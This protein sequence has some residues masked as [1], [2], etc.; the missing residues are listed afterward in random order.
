MNN[1]PMSNPDFYAVLGVDKTA[2]PDDIKKAYRKLSMQHH[3]DRNQT[4]TTELFQQISQA[5][6][7]LGNP[8]KK[9]MYDMQRHAGPGGSFFM[10]SDFGGGGGGPTFFTTSVDVDPAELFNIFANMNFMPPGFMPQGS[11]PFN[12]E[13]LRNNLAKPPPILLTEEITLAKAYNGAT[14]PLQVTRWIMEQGTRREETE[15]VYLTIP[16]GVD[17]NELLILRDK[18]HVVSEQL[19]GDVKV[20][21]HVKNETSFIRDG[22]DLHFK[23]TITLKEALCGF[24]FDLEHVDGR[25][26]KI[27]NGAG[28]IVNNTYRKTIPKLGMVRDEHTGC[29]IIEFLVKFPDT[30]NTE[31]MDQLRAILP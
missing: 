10:N 4:D 1:A 28:H 7:T 12:M 17:N 27:N 25:V 23:K 22:L 5:Y 30:L 19:K 16:R 13:T 21:I 26:F 3:P 2:S 20:F 18:G 14:I 8:E 31:Q 24:A 9:R 11:K 15:T 29:L 6:D